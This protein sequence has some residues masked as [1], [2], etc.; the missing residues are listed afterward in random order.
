MFPKKDIISS[1][2]AV[3]DWKCELIAI[4]SVGEKQQAIERHI[5]VLE[6]FVLA[7]EEVVFLYSLYGPDQAEPNLP[8]T[9]SDSIRIS[10]RS[11]GNF[12]PRERSAISIAAHEEGDA[13][14]AKSVR[15]RIKSRH[16]EPPLSRLTVRHSRSRI[17]LLFINKESN[18]CSGT[19]CAGRAKLCPGSCRNPHA[20]P[21]YYTSAQ[22][23]RLRIAARLRCLVE[24]GKKRQQIAALQICLLAAVR[25]WTSGMRMWAFGS[26]WKRCLGLGLKAHSHWTVPR[27]SAKIIE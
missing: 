19:R 6:A 1:D 13:N 20:A 4:A 26:S 9:P 23:K 10:R 15:L 21:Y 11:L 22:A 5:Q 14:V 16:T 18:N 2:L 12:A 17:R 25:F 8:S 7:E 3:L 27:P 24:L